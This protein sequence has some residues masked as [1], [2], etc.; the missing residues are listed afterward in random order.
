MPREAQTKAPLQKALGRCPFA[1]ALIAMPY[2]ETTASSAVQDYVYKGDKS[3]VF[4]CALRSIALPRRD[5]F[6]K[7]I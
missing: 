2:L 1:P 5:H 3:K 7:Q 6:A 4:S